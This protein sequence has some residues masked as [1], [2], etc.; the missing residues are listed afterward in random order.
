[1][2]VREGFREQSWKRALHGLRFADANRI[3]ADR[4]RGIG[5]YV[6]RSESI[7]TLRLH[8][9]ISLLLRT[10]LNGKYQVAGVLAPLSADASRESTPVAVTQPQ[11]TPLADT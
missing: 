1:V 10:L 8:G 5:V 4:A 11:S 9:I 3:S 6:P 2:P 7:G